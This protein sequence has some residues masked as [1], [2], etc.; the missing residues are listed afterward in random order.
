M[1]IHK[2]KINKKKI[3]YKKIMVP[4]VFEIP[5]VIVKNIKNFDAFIALGCVIKGGNS[6][7]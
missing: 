6:T 2:L 5:F 4:G 1:G 7:F 3:K